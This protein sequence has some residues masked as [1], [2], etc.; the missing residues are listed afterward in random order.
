MMGRSVQTSL[1]NTTKLG[2]NEQ[3]AST[4]KLPFPLQ[5]TDDQ[6]SKL[7][8]LIPNHTRLESSL[9]MKMFLFRR[10]LVFNHVIQTQ[11]S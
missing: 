8:C 10:S 1:S 9:T 3:R 4:L 6:I 7:F 11:S 5:I 2:R